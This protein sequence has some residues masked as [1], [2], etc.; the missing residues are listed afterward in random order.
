M[1]KLNS[2]IKNGKKYQKEQDFL[3]NIFDLNKKI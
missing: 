1:Y 2:W 3:N